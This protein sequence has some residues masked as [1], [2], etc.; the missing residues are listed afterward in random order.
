MGIGRAMLNSNHPL[1]SE[2]LLVTALSSVTRTCI[3]MFA[4]QLAV[5]TSAGA[6]AT[7]ASGTPPLM[8]REKEIA[9]A[10]SSC[11]PS[12]ARN[13]SVYVLQ[14]SGYMKTRKGQNS[15]TA[16][17]QHATPTSQEPQ[18]MDAEGARAFLPR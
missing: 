9:L 6:Q 4:A 16:I 8:D 14:K 11:P 1:R 13:A 18:C 15:F 7:Q 2:R 10:L 3:L 5:V 12:V 17:V